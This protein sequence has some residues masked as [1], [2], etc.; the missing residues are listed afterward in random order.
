M[1]NFK[2]LEVEETDSGEFSWD[3]EE[4]GDEDGEFTWDEEEDGDDEM[5]TCDVDW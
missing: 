2:T 4:D 1:I 5:G 3:E